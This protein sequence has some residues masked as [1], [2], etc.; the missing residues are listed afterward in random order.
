MRARRIGVVQGA[1]VAVLAA[2]LLAPNVAAGPTA[3]VAKVIY[4]PLPKFHGS[5]D[6][7]ADAGSCA[8]AHMTKRLRWNGGALDAMRM[9]GVV[10]ADGNC[11]ASNSSPG[12]GSIPDLQG[13]AAVA[14][15]AYVLGWLTPGRT[16]LHGNFFMNLTT[17]VDFTEHLAV[18]APSACRL[19]YSAASSGCGAEISVS[20]AE[21]YALI[22][23]TN[24]SWGPWPGGYYYSWG[25]VLQWGLSWDSWSSYSCPWGVCTLSAANLSGLSGNT[26]ANSAWV[27]ENRTVVQQETDPLDLTAPY[28]LRATDRYVLYVRLVAGIYTSAWQ[29]NTLGGS[30][31]ALG[32]FDM[33]SHGLTG[34]GGGGFEV[35]NITLT[36]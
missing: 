34:H 36:T 12:P 9:A 10:S 11:T 1:I 15:T 16:R 23:E 22:D 30:A 25:W 26:T 28:N 7:V 2:I 8:S 33:F 13:Q 5:V 32:D 31:V 6:G 21:E 29:Q 20:V 19:N 24:S 27:Y 3:R 18:S 4:L 17:R 35:Q 14:G